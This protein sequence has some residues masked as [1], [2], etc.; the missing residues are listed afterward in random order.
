MTVAPHEDPQ[1]AQIASWQADLATL[2]ARIAPRFARPEVRARVG[3]FL[4]G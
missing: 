4:A 2:H 1:L 3:K